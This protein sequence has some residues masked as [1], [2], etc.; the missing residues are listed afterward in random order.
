MSVAILPM[1]ENDLPAASRIIGLAFGTFRGVPDPENFM[2]DINYAQVRWKAEPA[3]AFKAEIDGELV[4]SNF[5]TRWGSVGF[6]GPLSVR[7]DLWDRGIAKQLMEP[8]IDLFDHWGVTNAGL[9]TMA[10]SPKHLGLYQHFDFWPRN[11]T[12]IMNKTVQAGNGHAGWTL[13]SSVS[14]NNRN[15][16]IRSCREVTDTIYPGL[17]VEWEINAVHNQG[18]GD[19]VLLMEDDEIVGLGICHWG[20]DSEAGTDKCYIKFG[21]VKS[22][23]LSENRFGRL[24]EA[25][26]TVAFSNGLQILTGGVNTGRHEAYR[27]MFRHGFRSMTQGIVMQRANKQGYNKPRV[28][29]IDDWR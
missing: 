27:M 23:E 11:L 26:E 15:E 9:L 24:L 8:I 16:C 4:G 5:A 3:S 22:C 13:Y 19:T 25:C 20:P 14:K 28:F 10:H 18:I 7:P 21:A 2:S 12:A 6:F 1:T 29:L 17:D